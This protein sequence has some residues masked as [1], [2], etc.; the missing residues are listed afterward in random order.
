[1]REVFQFKSDYRNYSSL[2][3]RPR[4][5]LDLLRQLEELE[6]DSLP[7]FQIEPLPV[8]RSLTGFH[9]AERNTL[10]FGDNAYLTPGII[11]LSSRARE[12]LQSVIDGNGV[13]IPLES[14][15]GDFVG[16]FPLTV[17]DASIF[18]VPRTDIRFW[19]DKDLKAFR[20]GNG[21]VCFQPDQLETLPPVFR[22]MN[23]R[24][25][26]LV[27][28]EFMNVVRSEGL[29]GFACEQIYPPPDPEIER[30]KYLQ[31]RQQEKCRGIPPQTRIETSRGRESKEKETENQKATEENPNE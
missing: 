8:E 1:M 7:R 25:P 14:D 12:A 3:F 29:T 27:T 31:K 17:R 13:Y 18:D 15:I 20:S 26:I 21:K 2:D 16:F 6:L 11:C 22:V 28:E 23:R 5:S 24:G 10:P 4:Q 30:R 9:V 19:P